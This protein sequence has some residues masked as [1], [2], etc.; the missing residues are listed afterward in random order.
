MGEL[1]LRSIFQ[2]TQTLELTQEGMQVDRKN[3]PRETILGSVIASDS[4]QVRC[5]FRYGPVLFNGSHGLIQSVVRAPSV[6]KVLCIKK[7]KPS[8]YSLCAEALLQWLASNALEAAGIFCAI[9]KVYDIFQFAGETRFSMEYVQGKSSIQIILEAEDPE[10]ALTHILAQTALLLGYL[11]ETIHLDHRDLKADN[12]WV[13]PVPIHYRLKVGE[14]V[15]SLTSPFQVVLLDFG[16]A[17]LGNNDGNAVVNLS[18]GVLPKVDPCPKEGRDLFQFLI[19]LLSVDRVR[20]KFSRTFYRQILDLIAE[21]EDTKRGLPSYVDLLERTD[22]SQWSYLIVSDPHFKH[23]ALSPCRL[24][25][26]L[27]SKWQPNIQIQIE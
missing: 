7:P 6:G 10:R 16:F 5:H 17:C 9:P 19:S 22:R 1:D 21:S 12:L 8:G 11:Q 20:T 24:L 2:I 4:K 18:D 14:R 3:L 13:R 23:S 15:W 27:R 26:Q 25:E